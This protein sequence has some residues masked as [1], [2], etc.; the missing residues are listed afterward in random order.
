VNRKILVMGLPGSGKTTLCQVLATRLNAVHFNND[1]V[2]TNVNKDLGFSLEDRLEQARRMGFLCDLVVRSGGIAIGDF[3]CPTPETRAAFG[4]AFI[5][6]VDRIA[7]GRFEDTNRIFVPPERFDFRVEADGS[8]EYW[9]E[10]IIRQMRPVFDPKKPTALFI[11]RYQPFHEGH[12][13]LIEEGLARVGQVCIAVRDVH[14][15]DP[16]NPLS[17]EDVRAR[18]ETA[19]AVHAGRF[20]VM[21]LPNVSHVFYGRDVG[22]AIERIELDAATHAISATSL[23]KSAGLDAG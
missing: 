12:R 15:I 19:L 3:I 21:P 16:A 8:P 5:V 22:Y 9:V 11:G 20:V 2:R 1:E 13:A 6:W 14:G 23:R 18:I 4:D 10:R 7:A 17:Y